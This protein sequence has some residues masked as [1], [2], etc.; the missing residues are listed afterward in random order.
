MSNP[1]QLFNDLSARGIR[2][3]AESGKLK[4][5]T[6]QGKLADADR[7]LL[8]NH[9]AAFL[10]LLADTLCPRCNQPLAASG[11]YHS[12]CDAGHYDSQSPIPAA[13]AA[14]YCGLHHDP[15]TDGKCA[16]CEPTTETP[17][18]ESTSVTSHNHIDPW[19]DH[20]K[21]CGTLLT[22]GS[23]TLCAKPLPF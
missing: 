19:K 14:N 17:F 1:L 5:K 15:L 16:R 12:W 2:L 11:P 6:S 18:I 9:K 13:E 20:C 4:F 10:R 23:C 8:R 7:E 3:W 21:R 22:G